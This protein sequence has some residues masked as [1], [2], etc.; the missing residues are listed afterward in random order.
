M[1]LYGAA[2]VADQL[3]GFGAADVIDRRNVPQLFSG[4]SE[5]IQRMIRMLLDSQSR[6]DEELAP[7]GPLH[8]WHT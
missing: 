4:Q 1:P 6:T 7:L 8:D 3:A 5:H 2:L